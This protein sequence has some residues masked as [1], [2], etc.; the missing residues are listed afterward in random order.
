MFLKITLEIL[1]LL[2]IIGGFYYGLERGFIRIAAKP[3]KIL[4]CFVLAF[5]FC[6]SIGTN[7]VAPLIQAPITNYIKEYMY[8]NCAALTPENALKNTPTI[9][10][11][12]ASAFDVELSNSEEGTSGAFLEKI[13]LNLT[14]PAVLLISII[15]AFVLIY[16]LSKLL[17][18]GATLIVSS[19]FEIGVLAKINRI[20][21]VVLAGLMSLLVAWAAV[22]V[23]DFLFHLSIFDK[24]SFIRGFDGGPLYRLFKSISPIGIL[25]SF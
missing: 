25:L 22:A 9:L 14:S 21:G 20:M 3:I 11:I 24:V 7:I 8:E 10:K 2:V 12:A 5:S 1:L 18:S 23:I 4:L 15:I 13:I 16:L 17:L 19:V 6:K